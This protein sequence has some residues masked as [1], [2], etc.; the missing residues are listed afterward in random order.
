MLGTPRPGTRGPPPVPP[1]GPGTRD[2]PPPHRTSEPD[3][4]QH[5]DLGVLHTRAVKIQR[6]M[7]QSSN[8]MYEFLSGKTFGNLANWMLRGQMGALSTE[9]P[10]QGNTFT[11]E[12]NPNRITVIKVSQTPEILLFALGPIGCIG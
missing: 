6:R 1:P 2:P 7:E 9:Q 3:L 11:A 5:L 4:P 12:E 10:L 8:Q